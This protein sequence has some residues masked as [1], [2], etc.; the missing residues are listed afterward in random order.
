MNNI[1]PVARALAA[2]NI[3]Q[4]V[5]RHPGP[6]HSLEQAAR[7]RSQAPD[8]VV[9]SIVFR[10]AKDEFL[11]VLV[12]GE[13]Q[14]SW[15]ALRRYL[16]KARLSLAS[17]AEVLAATG[18]ERGAVSPFGLPNPMRILLDESVLVNAEISIG[19]GERGVTVILRSEDLKR[20]L[21]EVEIGRFAED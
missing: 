14:V 21:G 13:R 10:V 18:Y 20:A 7:E 8:Q 19:S 15:P 4:R 1:P 2:L 12:A 17:E 3:P 16:G 6:V 11:M 9:R 5:F